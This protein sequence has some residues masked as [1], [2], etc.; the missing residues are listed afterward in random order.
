[1][2]YPRIYVLYKWQK[3]FISLK[4]TQ[5]LISAMEMRCEILVLSAVAK[6]S[7]GRDDKCVAQDSHKRNAQ[8]QL[9]SC[10][11]TLAELIR[12]DV[13]RKESGRLQIITQWG[14]AY[15]KIS[16]T[17]GFEIWFRNNASLVCLSSDDRK[18][19][20]ANPLLPLV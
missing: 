18:E 10:L 2:I 5:P 16:Y 19:F 13:W 9:S 11:W 15:N 12:V 3:T 8:Q 7:I 20:W 14:A 17:E 6:S 1:M 4:S